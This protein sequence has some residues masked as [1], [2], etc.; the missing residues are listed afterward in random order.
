MSNPRR[1]MTH[2]PTVD[3]VV[4]PPM[5]ERPN[6]HAERRGFRHRESAPIGIYLRVPNGGG[7]VCLARRRSRSITVVPS[8]GSA[9][10][11]G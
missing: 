3:C 1:R 6:F 8:R 5:R 2:R 4:D 9:N 10:V 11:P 7:L